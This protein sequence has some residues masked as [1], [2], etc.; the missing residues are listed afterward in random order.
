ITTGYRC[1]TTPLCRHFAKRRYSPGSWLSAPKAP[2]P[3]T[4]WP[5]SRVTHCYLARRAV[6]YLHTCSQ[7]SSPSRSCASPCSPQA[8]ASISRMLWLLCSMRPGGSWVL[9]AG[10]SWGFIDLLQLHNAFEHTQ[11]VLFLS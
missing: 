4:I 3:T 2:V 9:S 6:A 5:I 7:V 8:V 1:S 11:P 10:D